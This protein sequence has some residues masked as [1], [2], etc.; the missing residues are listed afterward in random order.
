MLKPSM[1]RSHQ[2]SW[3]SLFRLLAVWKHA[4]ALAA[5]GRTEK[6]NLVHMWR[7]KM[8]Y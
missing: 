5:V 8:L 2:E 6:M 7:L 4:V 1:P 3:W